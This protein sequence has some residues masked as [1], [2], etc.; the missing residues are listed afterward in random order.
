M[1][2][3][4]VSRKHVTSLR[5][6]LSLSLSS[7][8]ISYVFFC[9]IKHTFTYFCVLFFVLISQMHFKNRVTSKTTMQSNQINVC[10]RVFFHSHDVHD[11]APFAHLIHSKFRL[12]LEFSSFHRLS[13][14]IQKKCVCN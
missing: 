9:F 8:L 13:L 1:C 10:I 14:A 4:S 3:M 11:V 5:F 6:S 12:R 2:I 7:S